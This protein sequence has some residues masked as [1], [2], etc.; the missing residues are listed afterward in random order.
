MLVIMHGVELALQLGYQK[1]QIVSDSS[2]AI[3]IINTCVDRASTMDLL[4]GDVMRSATLFFAS[5]F[6]SISRNNN[7]IAPRLAKIALSSG[8]KLVWIEEPPTVIQD[9]L[10]QETM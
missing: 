3:S 5:K 4:A 1:L 10:I 6:I 2:E 8:S 9:L 7:G